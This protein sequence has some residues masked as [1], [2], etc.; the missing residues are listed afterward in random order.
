LARFAPERVEKIAVLSLNLSTAGVGFVEGV[1]LKSVPEFVGEIMLALEGR[2]PANAAVP[3]QF[4]LIRMLQFAELARKTIE[5]KSRDVM[6]CSEPPP[7]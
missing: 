1:T 7:V 6:T 3:E 2:G 4:G 5:R